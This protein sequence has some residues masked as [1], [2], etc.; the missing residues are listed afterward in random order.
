M[1]KNQSKYSLRA[2]RHKPMVRSASSLGIIT[3]LLVVLVVGCTDEFLTKNPR[4]QRTLA[5]FYTSADDA[6]QATNATYEQ[7]RNFDHPDGFWSSVHYIWWLGMT[8]IASDDANKGTEPTDGTDVGRIDDLIYNPSEGVF[9]GVWDWYYRI[10]F[11]ANSAITNIPNIDM[12]ETDRDRLVAEN[13]FIRAYSYFFLVRAWGGVPLVTEPLEPSEFDQPRA[14]VQEVYVQIEQDLVD[15]VQALPPKSQYP[16]SQVGRATRGAAQ[17]L[18]AKVHLFQEEYEDALRLAEEVITSPDY[19]LQ[20]RYDE[21]FTAIGENGA[22]SLFEIQA[23]AV[24]DL[25]GR[26]TISNVQGIRGQPNLGWGFVSPERDLMDDYEPGDPRMQSTVLFVHETLP[27]GP[28]DVVRDNPAMIDERYNQKTFRPTDQPGGNLNSGTNLRRLRY[29]DVL[30]IAA[31]AA[32]HT[33]DMGKAQNYLNMV[34]ERA[35]DGQS[36]TIGIV[37]EGLST[38]LADT[39]G[40]PAMARR[41][42]VRWVNPGG[43]AEA[44]GLQALTWELVETN[45]VLLINT[46]DVIQSIDGVDI[47]TIQAYQDEIRAKSPGETVIVRIE[48]ISETFSGGSKSRDVDNE[49]VTVTTEEL[50]PDV[51]TGGQELLEAIWH[52]R[53]IELALEQHRMFDIRRQDRAGDLLRAQGKPFVDG[54][55]DLFPIPQRELDLNREM[56]QNPGYN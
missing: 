53:R 54:T 45:S 11:R 17:G 8:D 38:L 49:L 39:L 33:G 26:I 32:Y 50:L 4:G 22:G 12:D 2:M 44:E 20:Q 46:I 16:G 42:F 24:P 43:P 10:I 36:A 28:E 30:L 5:N 13:K 34:R 18:L 19:S 51:T 56:M 31:E 41:P 3:T 21:I 9:N 14:S 1:L 29:S 47:P 40:V 55:H 35:R 27:Q 25:S 52:E 15:A 6:I 23:A 37:P 48:R 7:M